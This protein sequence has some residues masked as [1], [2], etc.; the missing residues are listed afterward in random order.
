MTGFGDPPWLQ[1]IEGP[2]RDVVAAGERRLVALSGP[3][4]GKSFALKRRV[5]RLLAEGTE[6]S[7]ILVVTL[8]RTA[9]HDLKQELE[10]LEVDG[11]DEIVARTMHSYCFSLLSQS[12]VLGVC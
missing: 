1:G 4:T 7:R 11:A 5:W 2:A 10:S 8:T 6:A 3:G 12:H 9:A